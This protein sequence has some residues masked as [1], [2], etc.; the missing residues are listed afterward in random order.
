MATE[1]ISIADYVARVIQILREQQLFDLLSTSGSLEK[2]V[3]EYLRPGFLFDA[4]KLNDISFFAQ[5]MICSLSLHEEIH[6]FHCVCSSTFEWQLDKFM[7][8]RFRSQEFQSQFSIHKTK[9]VISKKLRI[10][11]QAMAT[12]LASLYLQQ[13][14]ISEP[15]FINY[16]K[17]E[18]N[19]EE[20]LRHVQGH[21]VSDVLAHQP[22]CTLH[23]EYVH[24]TRNGVIM[25]VVFLPVN[26]MSPMCPFVCIA[27]PNKKY[28]TE[29]QVIFCAKCGQGPFCLNS[30]CLEQCN[31]HGFNS[32][33][34]DTILEQI[35]RPACDLCH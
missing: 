20:T 1:R 29:D 14:C 22:P 26:L 21:T 30:N 15:S 4:A 7:A 17:D 13:Q 16:T 19:K 23:S 24:L 25:E 3:G 34:Y 2:I 31:H 9:R 32:E 8:S 35:R 11:W 6:G 12:A 27:C 5:A 18:N 10:D 28:L 33:A